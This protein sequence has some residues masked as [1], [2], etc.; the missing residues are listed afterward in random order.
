MADPTLTAPTRDPAWYTWRAD[1][2]LEDDPGSVARRV[3]SRGT[4]LGRLPHHGAARRSPP[5]A[6]RRGRLVH[7]QRLP[8]DRDPGADRARARRRSLPEPTGRPGRASHDARFGGAVP[9]HAVRGLPG[10]HHDPVPA[11]ARAGVRRCGAG[12]VGRACRRVPGEHR[13]RLHP[14]D[15]VRAVRGVADGRVRMACADQ[16]VPV[17]ARAALRRAVALGHRP[18]D[19]RRPRAVGIG[20]LGSGRVI[21]GCR[22]AASV[23]DRVLPPPPRRLDRVPASGDRRPADTRRLLPG[24]S[25]T[26]GGPDRRP[27]SSRWPRSGGCSRSRACSPS[28]WSRSSPT[29][30]S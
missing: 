10:Q 11:L 22:A 14:P 6:G 21:A 12:V 15:D 3:G 17:R 1:V 23:H 28:W 26:R 27:I 24:R 9:H 8:D 4:V 30:A 16:P 13:G 19:D 29:T 2:I 7:V 20:H 5:A 25:G 18:G